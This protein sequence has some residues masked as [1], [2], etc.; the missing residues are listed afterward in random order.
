MQWGGVYVYVYLFREDARKERVVEFL[1]C[2][3]IL[4]IN[5]AGHRPSRGIGHRP[6]RGIN[7]VIGHRPSRGSNLVIGH[8]PSRGI[9]RVELI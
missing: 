4:L 7:I 1:S 6:S 8:R 3:G 2:R 9:L 5:I